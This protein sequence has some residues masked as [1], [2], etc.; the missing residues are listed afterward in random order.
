MQLFWS[1]LKAIDVLRCVPIF[2]YLIIIIIIIIIL[3]YSR[4]FNSNAWMILYYDLWPN[5]NMPC[6]TLEMNLIKTIYI[7]LVGT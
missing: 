3:K 1:Q 5:V 7:R 6:G 2:D 4:T